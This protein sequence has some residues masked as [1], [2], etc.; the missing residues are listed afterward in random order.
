MGPALGGLSTQGLSTQGAQHSV[1][2]HSVA[3]RSA[4]H[5]A[6]L[7]PWGFSTQGG[8]ALT[9][10]QHLERLGPSTDPY[11]RARH[12]LRDRAHRLR[13]EPN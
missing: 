8:S 3:L 1:A 6:G 5:S 12:S 2:Q 9:G 11:R 13:N 4:Q 10:A 7:S